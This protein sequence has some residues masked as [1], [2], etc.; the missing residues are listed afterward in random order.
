VD[1]ER[2][3]ICPL[4]A[5]EAR[6]A[7]LARMARIGPV[8]EWK[9]EAGGLVLSSN[10]AAL[11]WVD[12]GAALCDASNVWPKKAH[13][14]DRTKEWGER[15]LKTLLHSWNI[16]NWII[17]WIWPNEGYCYYTCLISVW[18]AA[19]L[20]TIIGL[21]SLLIF[22]YYAFLTVC[23]ANLFAGNSNALNYG[24]CKPWFLQIFKEWYWFTHKS[25]KVY[26]T[27]NFKF[28]QSLHN[29]L[30]WRKETPILITVTQLGNWSSQNTIKQLGI[31]YHF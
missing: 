9:P 22:E 6:W 11:C 30:H 27:L 4:F 29:K 10:C 13:C 24:Q 19:A 25:N 23:I 31:F 2:D 17:I 18:T 28:T 21:F 8:K 1:R 26:I 7:E 14:S 20:Q 16:H 15:I 5:L 12:A 3:G